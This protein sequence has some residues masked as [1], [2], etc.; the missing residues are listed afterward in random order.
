MKAAIICKEILA[1]A[2]KGAPDIGT[3]YNGFVHIGNL[4]GAYAIYIITATGAQLTTIQAHVNCVGGLLVT[5]SGVRWP[6]LDQAI[7]AALRT[8]INVYRTN[9]GLST[10]PA[11]TTLLQVVRFAANHFDFGLFDVFDGS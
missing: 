7:P 3:G 2:N 9:Q 11:N 10:I 6:E 5:D 4:P 1:G 8:K